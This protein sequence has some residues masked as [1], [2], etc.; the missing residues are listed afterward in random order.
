MQAVTANEQWMRANILKPVLDGGE[1]TAIGATTL[2]EF[3]KY[4]EKD[5]A[6]ERCFQKVTVDEP[7]AEDSTSILRGIKERYKTHQHV[8]IKDEAI[9]AAVELPQRYINDR[10]LPDKAKDLVD[11]AASKLRM[12][13]NSMPIELDE[14]EHKIMQ[15]EIERE[16]IKRENEDQKVKELN[17]EIAEL[18][19]KRTALRARWQSEKEVIEGGQKI[20][21]QIEELKQRASNF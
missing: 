7:T 12:Q 4:F 3:Q 19:D 8:R 13:I 20:K 1:L 21:T 18:Q 6:L 9:I 2:N 5:K 17:K 16:A 11:E 15:L 14:V 10:F